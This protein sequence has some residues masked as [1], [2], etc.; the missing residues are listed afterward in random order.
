MTTSASSSETDQPAA[1]DRLATALQALGH[2]RGTNTSD[3]HAAAAERLG[4]EAVYRA[5]LANALLGAAQLEALLNESVEFDA[6]QRTAIY[7]QQQQTAGVTG[8]QT[9][10]LEFLRWQLLRIA[11]PL[12]EN[13]RTEQ[14][15]PVPV[16]AAQT[17]EGLDRLL[18]V[19]AASHTL[20]DQADIDSVAEQLDTAHQALSSAV[21]NID[22]LRAL[23]ERA[24]SGAGAEDSES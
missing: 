14:S 18:A 2:Y 9:S 21:E 12:R 15:G 3:E 16:A 17:A 13:A 24:R 22:R 4:G 10:M 11:S 7:L 1:V 6:E 19:S 8:D 20:T 23:T 5:Y